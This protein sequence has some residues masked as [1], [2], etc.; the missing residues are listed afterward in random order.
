VNI[1]YPRAEHAFLYRNYFTS[2]PSVAVHEVFSNVYPDKEVLNKTIHQLQKEIL[3]HNFFYLQQVL[4]FNK[5][6]DISAIP[7][8]NSTSAARIQYCQD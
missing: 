8:S 2:K 6:A 3:G 1:A 4:L 7:I 5:T